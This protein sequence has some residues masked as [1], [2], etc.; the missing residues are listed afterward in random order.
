MH[1]QALCT[2][3]GVR[4]H[5]LKRVTGIILVVKYKRFS[6]TYSLFDVIVNGFEYTF[7]TAGKHGF[8]SFLENVDLINYFCERKNKEFRISGIK[9]LHQPS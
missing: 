7:K 2:L 5:V 4:I 8:L 9:S 1:H 6:S 3:N